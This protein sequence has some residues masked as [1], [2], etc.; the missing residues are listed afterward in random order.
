MNSPSSWKS[1]AALSLFAAGLF[2][3]SGLAQ[4]TEQASD[5]EQPV[6]LETYKVTGSNITGIDAA[7][8]NPVAAIPRAVLDLGGYTNVGDALRS[9]SFV[10]GSSIIPTGSGNSFTPR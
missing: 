10:S 6:R 7:G 2:S 9:L 5:A 1:R 4:E 8:L 3:V